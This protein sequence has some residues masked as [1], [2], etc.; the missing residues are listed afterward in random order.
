MDVYE[1]I[2]HELWANKKGIECSQLTPYEVAQVFGEEALEII[3][4]V[5][6]LLWRRLLPLREQLVRIKEVARFRKWDKLALS[7]NEDCTIMA[8]PLKHSMHTFERNKQ[9][10]QFAQRRKATINNPTPNP[11]NVDT[12]AQAKAVPIMSLYSFEKIKSLGSK[13]QACCPFHGEKTA[14]FF[15]YTNNNSFHC[16]GCSANGSSIDFYMKL[17]NVQ[18]FDAVKALV[19][20]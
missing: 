17:N 16:F 12:I 3:P 11:V 10:L 6:K 8:S 7:F 5:N 13:T 18:F 2:Q 20:V 15:I 14:S 9:I 1:E 19:G 4:Q